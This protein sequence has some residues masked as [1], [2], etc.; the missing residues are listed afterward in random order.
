MRRFVIGDIHGAHKALVQCLERAGFDKENDKLFCLG[1]VVDR[2]REVK[3]SVDELLSI[4]NLVYV[5]GNHDKWALDWATTGEQPEMWL[6][7]GGKDTIESYGEKMDDSHVEFFKKAGLYHVED[8]RVFVHGG[9]NPTKPIEESEEKNFLWGRK[10]AKYCIQ[11][12]NHFV[13]KPVTDHDEIFLGH[14]HIDK[15]GHTVPLRN[16]N[17]C[18]MDTGAGHGGRLSMMDID[19]HEIYQSDPVSQ[20]YTS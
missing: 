8:N 7:Q 4:K 3:E 12:Y 16:S 6:K 15:F 14:T 5:M 9:F 17:I 10:L 18:L 11:N 2:N 13:D 1:D 19:S 20:L